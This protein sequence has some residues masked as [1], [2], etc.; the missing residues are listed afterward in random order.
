M[1]ERERGRE[2]AN[3]T[4][5]TCG[6]GQLPCL[7]SPHICREGGQELVSEAALVGDLDP[8][9][10]VIEFILCTQAKISLS[11]THTLC[12][13]PLEWWVS[14]ASLQAWEHMEFKHTPQRVT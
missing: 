1:S 14:E 9:T 13:L 12:D 11:L 5:P 7:H 6:S 3:L 2:R 10:S 4:L 8:E